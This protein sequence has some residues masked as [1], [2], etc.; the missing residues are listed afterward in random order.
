L[1]LLF[2]DD[3]LEECKENSEKDL[4]DKPSLETFAGKR[5]RNSWHGRHQRLV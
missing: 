2:I 4:T 5:V 1:L 3:K